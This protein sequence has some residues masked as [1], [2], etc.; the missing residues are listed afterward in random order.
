[1]TEG[2]SELA[3]LA[4]EIKREPSLSDRILNQYR[5]LKNAPKNPPRYLT[6]N[7]SSA[8]TVRCLRLAPKT[9]DCELGNP[10]LCEYMAFFRELI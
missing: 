4:G 7:H 3:G 8:E 5:E 9:R 1:M 10:K 2:G 6:N